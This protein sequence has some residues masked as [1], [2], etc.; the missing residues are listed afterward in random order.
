MREL[1][2]VVAADASAA[3]SLAFEPR[4]RW[5][6][7]ALIGG[8]LTID[9]LIIAISALLADL[10]YK[11]FLTQSGPELGESI[12]I[13]LFATAIFSGFVAWRGGFDV[14]AIADAR[15]QSRLAAQGWIFVFFM[16][17][18][19]AFLTK[20]TASYSRGAILTWFVFGGLALQA[21][22]Y[23]GSVWLSRRL[24]R[25]ELSLSRVHVVAVAEADRYH[26]MSGRLAELGIEPVG[27]TTIPTSKLGRPDFY[28]ACVTAADDARR[29]LA[30]SGVDAVHVFVP[31]NNRRAF[32]ELRAVLSTLP[33]PVLL[34]AD[35]NAQHL[36]AHRRQTFGDLDAFEVQRAPLSFAERAVKRLLD[37][38]VAGTAL[39]LL[40]PLMLMTALAIMVETGRPIFFLQDRKGF[41][42]RLFRI[43][44]FRTMTV[45]EN[46]PQV[47]QA[48]RGDPRITPLG[49]ILRRTSLDELPQL[50]NVLRGEMSIVGPRPH[51]VA[52][53]NLYD[54][55]IGT[56]ALRHHVKPG[57]TGWA[58]VHG[59]RGE[60]REDS[61]M[62]AR[63]ELDLWYI[64]NWSF[65]LD[66]RIIMR[67][68]VM[69][70]VD[71]NA[72]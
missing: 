56:Y 52:H 27:V 48:R 13:G 40:S 3:E 53:D 72:Y 20:M 66:L 47:E 60:T 41:G 50:V 62:E 71:R 18:W 55:R 43:L 7:E 30:Q 1:D 68:A 51:A 63:V 59:F 12:R 54:R 25:R 70:L 24:S 65:W 21:F 49:R 4:I 39:V 9:V 34:F 16:I 10:S 31:W 17:G 44:K 2:M 45:Q 19:G 6:R 26:A 33:V 64:N 14:E 8:I 38:A 37:I 32:D 69:V 36:L 58:Q 57:I 5:S 67:T 61:Q 46:G 42:G 11:S 15:R 35:D 23:F 28:R 29:S 22:H